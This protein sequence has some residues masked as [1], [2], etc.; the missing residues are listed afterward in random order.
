MIREYVN[1]LMENLPETITATK[2]PI[3]IDLILGGGTFNG[4]YIL[5]A[6]HFLK[7][8]ERK[9]YITIQR[10]ST[11]SVSSV[12]A[13]LYFTDNLEKG[14]EW[15]S[16]I[17]E[18]FREKC[19]L[20][21]LLTLKHMVNEKI[22]ME[23]CSFLNKRL[24]ICFNDINTFKKTVVCNFKNTDHLFECI[25]KSCFVP[26][27]IDFNPCYKN[28]YIDGVVPH[29]FKTKNKRKNGRK[30]NAKRIYLDVY[31]LDKLFYS[32]SIKNEKTNYHRL[33]E[34]MLD[35]HHFFIK[36]SNTVM[37]SDLD[38]WTVR[39]YLLHIVYLLT[40]RVVLYFILFVNTIKSS[41][42][43]Q[44]N[45]KYIHSIIERILKVVLFKVCF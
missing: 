15:Y 20:S 4:S 42:I 12:L 25:I 1:K 35:I 23:D 29:F 27:L 30:T 28:A 2:N 33:F 39:N 6:L 18:D 16:D 7:E 13:L 43:M 37:C 14:S 24:Y 44:N 21:K 11:C 22:H 32:I 8:M 34:G 17:L 26:F 45:Y 10:I 38:K 36:N 31:T 9:N 19:N 40:E 5:G 3:Q 41:L